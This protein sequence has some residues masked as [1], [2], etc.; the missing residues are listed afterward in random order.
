MTQNNLAR[1]R[2]DGTFADVTAA[3]SLGF[4]ASTMGA[5]YGDL[6]ND[7]WPE[8][9]FGTGARPR[10]PTQPDISLA[11]RHPPCCAEQ[12]LMSWDT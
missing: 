4:S 7:G 6:D 10:C 5:N 2:G 3:V 11:W 8:I 9:Y 1:N 12:R